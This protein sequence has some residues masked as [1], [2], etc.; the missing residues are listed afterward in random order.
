MRFAVKGAGAL[1]GYSAGGWRRL[2]AIAAKMLR[3]GMMVPMAD[4]ILQELSG[5]ADDAGLVR[6][7]HN[8]D[9]AGHRTDPRQSGLRRHV[10][11][12]DGRDR[13]SGG[14]RTA[15]VAARDSR[16][17]MGIYSWP[18]IGRAFPDAG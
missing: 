2:A 6:L 3:A 17:P 12:L 11:R 14:G 5:K 8:A 13:G 7:G 18:A 4:N 10:L 9:P 15:K 1:G 16:M